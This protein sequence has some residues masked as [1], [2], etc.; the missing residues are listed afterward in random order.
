MAKY[1]YLADDDA[2]IVWALAGELGRGVRKIP[3]WRRDWLR[4]GTTAPTPRRPASHPVARS[5]PAAR[6]RARRIQQY[7]ARFVEG[8]ARPSGLPPRLFA[9]ATLN[10][11]PDVLRVIAASRA[12]ARY[13]TCRRRRGILERPAHAGARLRGEDPFADEACDNPLLRDW[14]AAGRTSWPCSAVTRVVHPSGEIA[15]YVDPERAHGALRDSL[16]QRMRADLFHRR[17]EASAR[18]AEVERADPSLQFHA[19]H[20]RLRELQ[21]LHRPPARAAGRPRRPAAAAAPRSRVLAP[22]IDPHCR[23]STP[24]FG[25]CRRGGHGERD[26]VPRSPTPVRSPAN[27]VGRGFLRLL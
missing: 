26:P 17:G 7:L 14:G 4:A 21:V 16:L 20:T 9:F 23:I 3:A 19:C 1:A 6:N 22:D 2:V 13:S 12:S 8:D 15:A 11:S 10:V 5:S 24:V 27:Q 25:E 18:R